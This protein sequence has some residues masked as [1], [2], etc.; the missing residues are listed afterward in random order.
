MKLWWLADMGFAYDNVP[1]DKWPALRQRLIDD[2]PLTRE[3]IVNNTLEVFNDILST[4]IGRDG[5]RYVKDIKLPGDTFG[6]LFET[7]FLRRLDATRWRKGGQQDELDVVHN[8]TPS[9]SFEI[10]TTSKRKIYGSK[11]VNLDPAKTNSGSYHL[12]VFWD[13]VPW[14]SIGYI[15]WGWLDRSDFTASAS[16]YSRPLKNDARKL[17]CE[18]LYRRGDVPEPALAQILEEGGFGYAGMR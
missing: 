17:K 6:V 9:F 3:L 11:S 1:P 18:T 13:L 12:L 16:T 14:P 4:R 5:L 2:H 10:K 7:L 8:I 15:A